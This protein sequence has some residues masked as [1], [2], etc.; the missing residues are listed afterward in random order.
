MGSPQGCNIKKICESG[1][2]DPEGPGELNSRLAKAGWTK[3]QRQ[4]KQFFIEL[5]TMVKSAGRLAGAGQWKIKVCKNYFLSTLASTCLNPQGDEHEDKTGR[6]GRQRQ[7]KL[8]LNANLVQPTL[9]PKVT[10][11]SLSTFRV[12]ETG[13]IEPA[14]GGIS[15]ARMN[16]VSGR[17]KRYRFEKAWNLWGSS[18][19]VRVEPGDKG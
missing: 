13:S 7:G 2:R 11:A 10:Y 16:E 8:Q 18:V 6:T 14:D 19:Q 1:S 4:G 12:H 9:N 5:R 17:I 3:H 15:S